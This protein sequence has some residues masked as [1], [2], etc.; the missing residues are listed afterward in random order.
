MTILSHSLK[1]DTQFIIEIVRRCDASTELSIYL[2]IKHGD[3]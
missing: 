2:S 3:R 1:V